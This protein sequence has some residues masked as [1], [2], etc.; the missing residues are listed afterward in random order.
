M[1][2]PLFAIIDTETTGMRSEKDRVIE[3]GVLLV[4][5]GE[6]LRTFKTLLNPGKPI[7]SFITGINGITNDD[8]ISAPSFDEVALELEEILKGAVFVAHNASFDY[9]FIK[10]E[11]KRLGMQFSAPRLCSVE[12]SRALFPQYRS[13]NLDAV[14]ARHSLSCQAR[15]RAYD[16]AHAVYQFLEK[17]EEEFDKE[18]LYRTIDDLIVGGPITT[19]DRKEIKTLPD[20]PGVYYFYDEAG[21]P[22]YIGKSKNIRTR[23]RTHFSKSAN[24][25][26]LR[27]DTARVE[28]EETPGEL[29]ALLLESHRIKEQLPRYNRALRKPKKMVV[30]LEVLLPSGYRTVELVSQ[31]EVT[32]QKETLALF[33][34]MTQ[35]KDKLREIARNHKL[36]EKLLGLEK[37][38]SE[39]CFGSQI[40]LCNGACGGKENSTEYNARFIDAF[41]R[42]RIKTWPFRDTI[43]IDEPGAREGVGAFFLVKD[44]KIVASYLYED[45]ALREFLPKGAGFDYDTYKLLVRYILNPVNKS[46]VKEISH[47]EFKRTY[48]E[49]EG[50]YEA[51]IY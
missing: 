43:L 2:I 11:F 41:R 32:L 19:L 16:D 27:I 22:V 12:L 7:S 50:E 8:L 24:E 40:E 37:S 51:V 36:C 33:R 4:R 17:L 5:D 26:H 3:I 47:S 38:A 6:I 10:A 20:T 1:S 34:T 14:I 18:T 45:G 31:T 35:G 21:E 49:L 13:H 30:A 39:R 9:G 46:R 15:H 23:V 42:R 48:M 44:W 29:S 28:I 25:E